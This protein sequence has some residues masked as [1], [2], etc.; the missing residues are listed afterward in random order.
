M[1]LNVCLFFYEL[2]LCVCFHQAELTVFFP[3]WGALAGP[4]ERDKESPES[5][6][7]GRGRA[8]ESPALL[9]EQQRGWEGGGEGTRGLPPFQFQNRKRGEREG[10]GRGGGGKGG[11]AGRAKVRRSQERE[12]SA[13][14]WGVHGLERASA[15]GSEP[16][17]SPRTVV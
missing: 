10:G 9:A 3:I 12:L 17:P 1:Q 7:V 4:L 11:R 2:P 5:C 14:W 6:W 8:C 16:H 13:G 15:R